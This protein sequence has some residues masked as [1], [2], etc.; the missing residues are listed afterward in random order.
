[1]AKSKREFYELPNIA[2]SS[3]I[4]NAAR[5]SIKAAG[6][7]R[8]YVSSHR[9]LKDILYPKYWIIFLKHLFIAFLQ[10]VCF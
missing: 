4:I 5:H 8:P 10:S 7:S 6:T 3:D 2:T 1:M 9:M